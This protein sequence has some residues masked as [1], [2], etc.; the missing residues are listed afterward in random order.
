MRSLLFLCFLGLAAFA[1]AV[2]DLDGIPQELAA[3]DDGSTPDN[4]PWSWEEVDGKKFKV[5]KHED[6][7]PHGFSKKVFIKKTR[8][9]IIKYIRLKKCGCRVETTRKTWTGPHKKLWYDDKH[10]HHHHG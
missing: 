6:R 1:Y 4:G 10:H 8:D 2:E 7:I 9:H 3:A 5:Y